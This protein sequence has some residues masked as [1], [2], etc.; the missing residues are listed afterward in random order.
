VR[1]APH[2]DRV[3]IITDKPNLSSREGRKKTQEWKEQQRQADPNLGRE[4]MKKLF[5]DLILRA[6]KT[7][8]DNNNIMNNLSQEELRNLKAAIKDPTLLDEVREAG[9]SS[10]KLANFLQRLV[11]KPSAGAADQPSAG[12]A[13]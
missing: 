1:S 11:G 10:I 4:R 7:A 6:T 5:T 2:P 12:P 3:Q 9:Q 13:A 8:S